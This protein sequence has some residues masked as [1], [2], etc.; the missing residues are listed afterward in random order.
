MLAVRLPHEHAALR[1]FHRDELQRRVLL[2]KVAP[3][4]V[5]GAA[6]A[7]TA[8]E[9]VDLAPALLPDLGASRLVVRRRVVLV[10]KLRRAPHVGVLGEH[11]PEVSQ[12][13]RHTLGARRQVHLRA[14]LAADDVALVHGGQLGHHDDRLVPLCRRCHGHADAGVAARGLNDGRFARRDEPPLLRP[15]YHSLGDAVLHGTSR[16]LRLH[17]A[18]HRHTFGGAP[19]QLYQR[20]VPD[21]VHYTVHIPYLLLSLNLAHDDPHG[22]GSFCDR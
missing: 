22:V 2:L 17:L 5:A 1:G 13:A 21:R 11:V 3:H 7:H 14:E 8:H 6:G 9:V 20:C 19:L 18:Q 10:L 15:L 4:A 16:V 12:H